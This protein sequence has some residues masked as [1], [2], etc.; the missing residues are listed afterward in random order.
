MTLLKKNLKKT[1]PTNPIW[2][3]AQDRQKRE[4]LKKFRLNQ[5]REWEAEQEIKDYNDYD[6]R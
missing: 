2:Y 3:D 6:S 1:K 4:Q 5:Q